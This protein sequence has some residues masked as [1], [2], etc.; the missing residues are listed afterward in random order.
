MNLELNKNYILLHEN[1][2]KFFFYG[3][4]VILVG[5]CFIDGIVCTCHSRKILDNYF[6]GCFKAQ[7]A[8]VSAF[9]SCFLYKKKI[10]KLGCGS[11][12]SI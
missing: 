2:T 1:N 11:S 10:K 3:F 6:S 7:K 8:A 5:F 9:E 4:S 12:S